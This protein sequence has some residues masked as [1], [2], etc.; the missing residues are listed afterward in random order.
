MR[1]DIGA[2]VR[3]AVRDAVLVL[4]TGAAMV[5]DARLL[6]QGGGGSIAVG[7]T[8]GTL[9]ALS[10]FFAHEWGHWLGAVAT[11]G[12]VHAPRKLHSF[13]L[14]FFDTGASTRRQFLAMSYGGYAATLV[15]LVVL[16]G[17]ARIEA[18]SGRTALVLAGLGMTITAVLEIPTTWR[19][20]RG[21]PLPSGFVFVG[22]DG[23]G[24][25]PSSPRT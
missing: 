24:A 19:V 17:W 1:T 16:G 9:F 7:V 14:F 3:F 5:W 18:W 6:A 21:A 11:G 20:A 23:R 22:P 4:A 8:A 2:F 10:A 12:V 13:F 25:L 15:A